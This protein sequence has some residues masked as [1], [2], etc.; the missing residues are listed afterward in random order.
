MLNAGWTYTQKFDKV[1]VALT[2]GTTEP[3]NYYSI[4]LLP[5]LQPSFKMTSVFNIQAL[6][7]NQWVFDLKQFKIQAAFYF[8]YNYYGQVCGGVGHNRDAVTA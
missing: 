7:F 5:Y 8:I 4:T 1:N 6:Y 2:D 3:L